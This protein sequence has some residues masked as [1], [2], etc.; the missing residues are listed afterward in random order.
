MVKMT[1]ICTMYLQNIPSKS[2]TCVKELEI[3]A[4]F[5]YYCEI[6]YETF[7][8]GLLRINFLFLFDE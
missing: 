2:H 5:Y 6:P 7:A 4:V 8:T 1:M 3:S